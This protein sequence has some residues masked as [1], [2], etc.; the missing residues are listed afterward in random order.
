M[1]DNKL[2]QDEKQTP[3]EISEDELEQVSG[4]MESGANLSEIHFKYLGNLVNG[5]ISKKNPIGDI[6]S[7][8]T[9]K[10]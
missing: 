7:S 8:K 4:G 5:D 6:P 3:E 10:L 2:N 1:A 9:V